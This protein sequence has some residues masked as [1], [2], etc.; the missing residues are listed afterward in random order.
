MY[1]YSQVFAVDADPATAEKHLDLALRFL[2]EGKALVDR[3]PVQASEKPY[4][5][6]E[7]VVKTLTICYN[8]S[9]VLDVV[10]EKGRWT[11]AELEEAVELISKRVG[12]WF[13]ASWESANYLHVWGFHEAK[14]DAEAVKIRAR[15]VEKIVLE[16]KKIVEDKATCTH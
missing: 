9:E 16:A 7:E 15:Y 14:L 1:S 13:I 12:K 10:E 11:V 3:D 4:K 6:A 8:L 5:A 2:E